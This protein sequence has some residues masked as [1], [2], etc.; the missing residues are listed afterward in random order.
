MGIPT[1]RQSAALREALDALV[2]EGVATVIV[3]DDDDQPL[4]A[5]DVVGV[6][7]ALH[8]AMIDTD[9]DSFIW[10][11]WVGRHTQQIRTPRS[12]TSA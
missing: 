9:K 2:A 5:L 10:W 6:A 3:T 7:A 1:V 11:D 4:G 12:S 8:G